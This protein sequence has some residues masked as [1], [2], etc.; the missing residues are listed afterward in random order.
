MQHLNRVIQLLLGV[1][2]CKGLTFQ[3][4]IGLLTFY[5]QQNV[6]VTEEASFTTYGIYGL[7]T[8][9]ILVMVARAI[10][11]LPAFY[12]IIGATTLSAIV[13]MLL[14]LLQNQAWASIILAATVM[15]VADGLG[16][17]GMTLAMKRV[18]YA[19]YP[20]DE[21]KQSQRLDLYI[22]LD[23]GIGNLGAVVGS[24]CFV[25]L[26]HLFAHDFAVANAALLLLNISM[27]FVILALVLVGLFYVDTAD[28]AM[29]NP[30][31]SSHHC[32]SAYRTRTFWIYLLVCTI[33]IPVRTLFRHID[34]TVPAFLTHVLGSSADFPYIQA[35]NPSVTVVGVLIL[36][37]IRYNYPL[38]AII[39]RG[40][41]YWAIVSGTFICSAGFITFGLMLLEPHT[42][43][44]LAASIG[45]LIFS[46]GEVYWSS[47]FTSYALSQAPQGQE[48]SY[49]ALV[50]LPS[51]AVK[52]PTSLLS[53]ALI[54]NYCAV[55]TPVA[56]CDGVRLFIVIGSI[57]LI[58]PVA[59]I[60]GAR[61]LNRKPPPKPRY[62]AT[63]NMKKRNQR[64]AVR[65]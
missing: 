31:D 52:L 30:R 19:Q 40:S 16:S 48:A 11:R 39:C 26:R 49:T 38:N 18:I 63:S 59:L 53:N 41:K 3:C 33:L 6:H 8:P 7:V 61:W 4:T 42:S 45:I 24:L 62:T 60:L 35:I 13:R 44:M 32:T 25:G 22:S 14:L 28:Q 54:K 10:D 9:I 2:F 55:A 47:I 27:H 37:L 29:Q 65:I 36:A 50:S 5:L 17:V 23:Y 46:V 43:P 21:T 56:S 1:S 64:Q 57:A 34:L 51:L 20:N 15:S 58:S 12:L